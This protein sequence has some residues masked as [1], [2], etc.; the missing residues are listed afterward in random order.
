MA[1]MTTVSELAQE[2]HMDKHR[3]YEWARREVDPLPLRQM[4]GMSRSSV[5]LV[6][7]W[8]DWFKRNSRLF[9][10]VSGER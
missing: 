7:D 6:E 9:K 4:D 2:C 10:E 3:F 8:V 1:V 5:I